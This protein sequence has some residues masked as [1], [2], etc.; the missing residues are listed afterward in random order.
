[1][2]PELDIAAGST[3]WQ[4][5]F[6]SFAVVV[7]LFELVRGWRLGLMRQIARICAVLAAYAV[8]IFGGRFVLPMAR[9]FLKA[10]DSI[11]ALSAGLVLALVTY[12]IISSLGAIFF[13]RTDQHRSLP[14][15]F[16]YGASGAAIGLFFGAFFVWLVVVG[17]RSLGAIADGQVE[18]QAIA[19][20]Q[21]VHTI[22][23][24]DSDPLPKTTAS[25]S[26]MPTL[27][28]LK[29]SIE[30]GR[31]GDLIKRTDLVSTQ[32]Y[33]I[34]GEVGELLSNP[35]AA[36][37]LLSFPGAKE[38]SEHPKIVALRNDPEIA[39]LIARGH[40]VDLLQND[41]V[42]DAA[43]DRELVN[44]IKKFDLKGALDYATQSQ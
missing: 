26:L 35:D 16:L 28:R 10:P 43:N 11:V 24:T 8:A 20:L 27:A 7:I 13:R 30:L 6:V 44:Q 33:E 3:I 21:A 23:S 31:V 34:L 40:F 25:A 17:V 39:D 2:K 29:N 5:V 36:E 38:L 1:M 37:R 19:P 14:V 4:I 12:S 9:T 42:L 15:R 32:T 18:A 41:K 22:L